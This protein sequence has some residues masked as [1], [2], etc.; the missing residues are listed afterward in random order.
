MKTEVTAQVSNKLA[1]T[2][3]ILGIL[4][5]IPGFALFVIGA[6]L[7]LGAV[8]TGAMG[9]S[10]ISREGTPGK[11]QAIAGIVLGAVAI[12]ADIVIGPIL[13]IAV[14]MILGPTIGNTFST[15]NNSLGTVTP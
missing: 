15:I 4:A 5:L 7:G 9:L 11:G 6:G 2:S 3:M 8:I 12:I 1:R 14:L 13:I 10:Q